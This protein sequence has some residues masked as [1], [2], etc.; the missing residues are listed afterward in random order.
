MP[1]I[2]PG[3]HLLGSST[4]FTMT[5]TQI[6]QAQAF[7]SEGT[8]R[9]GPTQPHELS[10]LAPFCCACRMYFRSLIAFGALLA[11]Q[12][13]MPTGPVKAQPSAI[14]RVTFEQSTG[15][16]AGPTASHM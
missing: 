1:W 15:E 5:R 7:Q 8:V 2:F 9:P 11:A 13:F 10:I 16:L 4:R 14:Q 3:I 12:A 6:R